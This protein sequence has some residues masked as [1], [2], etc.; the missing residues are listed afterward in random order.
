ME[1]TRR[2]ERITLGVSIG[3]DRREN[4]VQQLIHDYPDLIPTSQIEPAFAPLIPICQELATPAGYVDNI[5]LTPWGGIALAECKLFRNPQA[6]R[7]VVAQALDYARAIQGWH[8]D[9]LEAAVR[10]ATK[11]PEALLYDLV[12][13][14]TDLDEAEFADAVERNLRV[15][16]ILLLIVGEGIQ[17]GVEALTEFLQLHAG[18]HVGV[19]LVELSLWKLDDG[20][21]LVVPRV[22]MKTVVIERGIVVLDAT[23]P[24]RIAPPKTAVPGA[25]IEGQG[26]RV[27]LSEG[28]FFDRLDEKH[29]GLRDRL[30]AFVSEAAEFG[31]TLE[32]GKTAQLRLRPSPQTEASVGY[33]DTNGQVWFGGAYSSIKRTV[34]EEAADAY[35]E[36]ITTA[37]GG[38]VRR[39]EKGG[40]EI[41][42]ANGRGLD[43]SAL[44]DKAHAWKKA[45]AELAGHRSQDE[46]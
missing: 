22:P 41:L 32:T 26:R 9:D 38:Q 29:P 46:D 4:F 1:G 15:G 2:L 5:F 45:I 30:L 8:F 37:V 16:R 44:L 39:Y 19:A 7:E 10:K 23:S 33:V 31:I 24:V 11:R 25:Q 36:A 21:M 43:A 20:R 40:A 6:R 27:T 35:L 18:L 13:A 12:R 17:E 42:D 28:E 34:S 3:E 14:E